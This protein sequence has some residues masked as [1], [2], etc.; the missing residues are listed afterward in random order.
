META[1]QDLLNCQNQIAQ[2]PEEMIAELMAEKLEQL[3]TLSDEEFEFILLLDVLLDKNPE[4]AFELCST[5]LFHPF[6]ED[7]E[8]YILCLSCYPKER[9][10]P[11]FLKIAPSLKS[12]DEYGGNA[13]EKVLEKLLE[14]KVNLDAKTIK[15]ALKDSAF[16]V[17][18]IIIPYVLKG[19]F[20]PY[21]LILEKLTAKNDIYD[22]K[23]AKMVEAALNKR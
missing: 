16:R 5:A 1:N 18:R 20:K 7:K 12:I 11:L 4:L 21:I 9:V 8:H 17:Q 10:T 22:E 3:K 15:N 6:T 2:F 14:W 23:L 13:L 19:D